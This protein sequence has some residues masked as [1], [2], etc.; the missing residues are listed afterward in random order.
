M[1]ISSLTSG[2]LDVT[3]VVSQ[4]MQVERRPVDLLNN[5]SATYQT[6]LSVIGTLK[7]KVSDFQTAVKGL[8]DTGSFQSFNTT[9]SNTSALTASAG[10]TA[11]TGSYTLNVSSLAQTQQ[12]VAAGQA[13]STAAIGTGASTT[14]NFDFGTIT[15]GTLTSGTYTGATFTS[16]G[17]GVQTVTID[18]SNNTL[19][20]IRDA[21]N[22]ADIGVKASIINDG[23]TSPYRLVFSS[24][25]SGA[26]NSMSISVTGDATL[27]SLLSNDPAGTQNMAETLTAQNANF[28]LNGIAITKSSNTVTDVVEGV[29]LNLGAVTTSAVNLTVAKDTAAIN[30]AADTF[31]TEYNSLM[32]ELKTLSAYAGETGSAGS[33][34]GDPAV[35]QMITE[36]T[37]IISGTVTGGAYTTLNDVGIS[38]KPGVGLALDSTTFNNAISNNLDDL[39]NLFTSDEGFATKLDSWASTS[40]NITLTTRSSNISDAISN[41]A[42]E[43]ALREVRLASIEKR[44]TAQFTN[45]NMVLASMTA[46]QNFIASVFG[47]SSDS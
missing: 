24:A 10:A 47:G 7:S 36:L 43:V 19:E 3:S 28:D 46:Q 4:L 42:D 45:L 37:E 20:G 9:S 38:T 22:D 26:D 21:V 31:I 39:A 41:I 11:S 27:N 12:L 40:M 34:A 13:S 44:Y 29:T 5:K 23:G 32:S 2:S 25:A 1:D 16:G 14:L 15:G 18:S 33:L 30:A 17:A 8:K 35:R 6:Q